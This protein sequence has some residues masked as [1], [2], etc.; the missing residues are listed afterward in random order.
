MI[1]NITPAH[2]RFTQ[3]T[4]IYRD[5][6][7]PPR[8]DALFAAC[9]DTGFSQIQ[10]ESYAGFNGMH[11]DWKLHL[12]GTAYRMS[13]SL[14]FYY[15]DLLVYMG[16]RS[17]PAEVSLNRDRMTADIRVLRYRASRLSKYL[18]GHWE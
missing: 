4:P 6:P 11:E 15:R 9:Q 5:E 17:R 2:V 13:L 7:A 8:F 16:D 12:D 1:V 10:I 3:I 18:P 14:K